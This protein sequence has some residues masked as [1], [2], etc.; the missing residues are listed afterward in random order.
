MPVEDAARIRSS[1]MGSMVC[2]LGL[3]ILLFSLAALA[4]ATA[5]PKRILVLYWYNKDFSSNVIFDRSFQA[6]LKSAPAGSIEYYTEYVESD[7]FP[8]ENQYEA[9]RD[10]LRQKYANRPID[11]VVAVSD[12]PL[13]FLLKYRD[14]LF[15]Q[16]PIVFAAIKRPATNE[17]S[18]PGLTGIVLG[19]GYKKTLDLALR[20]HPSTKQVFI[21]SG[22]LNHDKKY[23]TLCREELKGLDSGISINY[24]T[25]FSVEELIFKT[26]RL[27]ERS[28]VLYIW[29]QSQNEQGQLMET[30]DVLN[31]IAPSTT[32]PIYGVAAWQI[33][34]GVVGGYLRS[35]EHD[36]SR[37][38]EIAL[39]IANGARAQDIPMESAET[40][41]MFD[42][43]ELH[44]W[45]LKESALP[46]GSLILNRQYTVW[47]S[48]RSYVIGGIFLILVETLLI[49]GLVWQRA[50]RR[51]AETQLAITF[52]AVRESERR[53]RLVANTAPVMIWTAGTDRKCS[54]VNQ[55]WLEFTGRPLEAE[56]GDGWVEGVHPDDSN[57]RLQTYTEAFN[58]RELFE[59][60]YRLRRKDGEYRWVL[61]D[62]VPRL[63]P[64]G[65][66]AGYIGSCIDIT[67]R[68]LAEESL[69]TIGRRLI[70]AHEEERTWLARELHDDIN[71]RIALL[72]VQ[73]EQWFQHP[74][75][76]EAEVAGHIRQ[77]RQQLSDLGKDVQA[78]SHRLHS[79][80]L[81]YLGIVSAAGGFCKELSEQKKVEIDFS[82]AGIPRSLP[83]EVSLCLFRVLQEA[84]QNAVKHSGERHFR[85]D[86]HGTS[87]ELQLTVND[88]GVG[89]DQQVATEHHGIGLVS[90]R[91]RLQLVGGEFSINS[92][93]GGG[94]T[95]RARIPL[96]AEEYRATVAG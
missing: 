72:G 67:E 13:E 59:L 48:Y 85:V 74:H 11:V 18:G 62:G 54:Y 40:V 79:S 12:V 4:K 96:T 95:I 22:T 71:Q 61:E 30:Q 87:S 47:E 38:G 86:L 26:K 76:S 89:F 34:R 7:R 44:R 10:Y 94:T 50:R 75:S 3:A 84:L 2:F 5:G 16:T 88:L 23:E 46:P 31:A 55:T 39:R 49:F 64:D 28:L 19:G 32:A 21:I 60:Q 53:F 14:N 24:F 68:K 41:P 93:P 35:F 6:S 33:G 8:G 58:R 36:A 27:P 70:E 17:T 20:L 66:F 52:E 83:K 65:A 15:T 78:L 43:G 73:L 91:E 42:W 51:T 37:M 80:K 9:L 92:K 82:H 1:G 45:D 56:L 81:E 90:M 63:N 77:V 29:Q 25:D 57:R 69:A